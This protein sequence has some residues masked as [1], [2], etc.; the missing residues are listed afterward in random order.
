MRSGNELDPATPYIN[1]KNVADEF[2]SSAVFVK[3]AGYGVS[4]S[5]GLSEVDINDDNISM[6]Q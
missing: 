3:Q 5:M 6:G 2:G 4:N 1:A